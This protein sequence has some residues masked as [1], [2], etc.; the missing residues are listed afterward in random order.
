MGRDASG[1][2]GTTQLEGRFD[3]IG[4]LIDPMQHTAVIKGYVENPG[5]RLRAGQ[6]VSATVQ[7]DPPA[8]VVEVPLTALVDDGKQSLV[9]V[10]TDPTKP[11]FTV[12]RVQVTNRFEKTAYVM[13]TPVPK[14][15][16]EDEED[17]LLPKEPLRPD[18][19]IIKTGA[20]ELKLALVQL[21]SKAASEAKQKKSKDEKK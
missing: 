9:F 3:E 10:Q 1:A 8:G 21:E 5:R 7:I 13:S 4:Y 16:S 15:D 18:E 19:R 6:Y 20:G 14:D 11:Q 17:G 12:R 2:M